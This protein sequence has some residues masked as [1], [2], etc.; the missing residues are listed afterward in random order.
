[1][2]VSRSQDMA[3]LAS[4]FS[5]RCRLSCWLGFAVSLLPT[6]FWASLRHPGSNTS[7]LYITDNIY[8]CKSGTWWS[9]PAYFSRQDPV[10]PQLVAAQQRDRGTGGLCGVDKVAWL[11]WMEMGMDRIITQ[12]FILHSHFQLCPQTVLSRTKRRLQQR[13]HPLHLTA[14]YKLVLRSMAVNL[15]IIRK[16][17]ML[18]LSAG[19]QR[20]FLR[21]FR[22]CSLPPLASVRNIAAFTVVTVKG[23][24]G[25]FLYTGTKERK[26]KKKK[27]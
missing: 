19:I 1:M 27:D 7:D 15:D 24:D 11:A 20:V 25:C 3:Q 26:T 14:T 2:F 21:Q 5:L 12:H 13:D 17:M 4:C 6:S 16:A 22:T 10:D 18:A 9:Y 23:F 8:V